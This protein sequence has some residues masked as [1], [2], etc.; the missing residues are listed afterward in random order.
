MNVTS[1][2]P[3]ERAQGTLVAAVRLMW[4]AGRLPL[5]GVLTLIEPVIRAVF[6]LAMVLGIF[7]AIVFEFSAAGPRFP[8][9]GV[10]ALSLG[11]G[12]A[13]VAYYGLMSLVSR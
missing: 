11:F 4:R 13:L 8:F 7:A 2:S 3:S 12:L 6:S 5:L 10:L 1:E 9:L